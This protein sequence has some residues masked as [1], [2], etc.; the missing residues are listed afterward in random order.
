MSAIR[1][2]AANNEAASCL[3]LSPASVLAFLSSESCVGT[4]LIL[5]AVLFFGL[6]VCRASISLSDG[7]VWQ[8]LQ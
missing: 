7:V 8:F 5:L 4:L 3:E 6:S 1:S 2:F